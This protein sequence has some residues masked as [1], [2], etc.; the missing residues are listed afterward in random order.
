MPYV[1]QFLLMW[2]CKSAYELLFENKVNFNTKTYE[3]KT[4]SLA[5]KGVAKVLA[6]SPTPKNF[7]YN[8][9]SPPR[10]VPLSP[11]R[12]AWC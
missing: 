11:S 9:P 1:N 6:R 7:F 10:P 4:F 12:V 2:R 3:M 8:L 5:L